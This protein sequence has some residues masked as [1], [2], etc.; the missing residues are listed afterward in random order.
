MIR[1]VVLDTETTGL[2]CD[3]GDR[4][5]E[6]GCIE[7]VDRRH[8]GRVFHH[9]FN[10]DRRSD[11]G[12]L[13]KHGIRDE[14]LLDKP[15]FPQLALE[16]VEFV[17]GAE[18]VIHNA[19]FDVRFL[20]LELDLAGLPFRCSGDDCQVFD[21]LALARRQWPGQRNSLDAL[22]KRLGIDNS[23]RELHGALL[24]ARLL[25]DVY[26]SMTAGQGALQLGEVSARASRA[27]S[28]VSF[29][30]AA[31]PLRRFLAPVRDLEAHARRLESV[32]R[33]SGGSSLWSIMEPVASAEST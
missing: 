18:L 10:P 1:Q 31:L 16:F 4:I 33:A 8:T 19:A 22:C 26:L 9:F 25:A 13:A 6:I 15:R 5:V 29:A 11:P 27:D 23:M 30:E 12:A 28:A 32:A 2:D 17:R 20:D 3:R 21:T 24:D 7:L 14:F